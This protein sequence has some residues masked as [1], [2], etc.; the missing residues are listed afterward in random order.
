MTEYKRAYGNAAWS[1]GIAM[2]A[3]FI[4]GFFGP[5]QKLEHVGINWYTKLSAIG[6]KSYYQGLTIHGVLNALVWTTFFIVGFFTFTMSFLKP[7]IELVVR[8]IRSMLLMEY[9]R[10]IWGLQ[11][12]IAAILILLIY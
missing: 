11:D 12:F 1:L 3:L 9:M 10:L 4:G 6:I 8:F 5:L 7:R 2:S